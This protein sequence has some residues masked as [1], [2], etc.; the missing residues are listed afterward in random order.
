MGKMKRTKRFL[1]IALCVFMVLSIMTF[2]ASAKTGKITA[3]D[4]FTVGNDI[5]ISYSGST[6]AKDWI[7]IYKA[8][9]TSVRNHIDWLYTPNESGTVTFPS[10]SN[11]DA[12]WALTP[13][14]YVAIYLWND[15]YHTEMD[16]LSFSIV[17]AEPTGPNE[18]YVKKGGTGDGRSEDAPAGAIPDVVENINS[19]GWTTGDLV[20]VYIID[21]GEAA[22]NA[23]TSDCV[24]GYNNNAVGQV[25]LHTAT[26]KYTNYDENTRTRIGHVNWMGA[27]SNATHFDLA[28]PSIFENVD[29][30]DMRNTGS[31]TEIYFNSYSAQ[32]ENCNFYVLEKSTGILKASEAHLQFGQNGKNRTYRS[33]SGIRPSLQLL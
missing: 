12:S 24:V 27:S 22:L 25:P 28:G 3:S 7:A 11:G 26:I 29:I 17:A 30:V 13:G 33:L 1:S 15:G 16:R 23:I 20:T 18:Y 4:T 9:D 10:G 8:S 31:V 6:V 14:D 5:I 19:D 2:T 32:F 21:S